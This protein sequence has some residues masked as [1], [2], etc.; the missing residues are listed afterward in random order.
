MK[1]FSNTLL[2]T[3]EFFYSLFTDIKEHDCIQTKA[4]SII[5][6]NDVRNKKIRLQSMKSGL[7]LQYLGKVSYCVR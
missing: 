3:P 5:G 7:F 4:N 1:V 2:K 6:I